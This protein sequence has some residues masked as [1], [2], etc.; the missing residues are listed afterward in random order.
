MIKVVGLR[1]GE[2]L[3]EELLNDTSKTIPT[4]HNK[5]MIAQEIQEEYETLHADIEELIKIANRF[6]NESIVAKMKEIV[7]E[8]KSMNSTYEVLDTH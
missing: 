4:Y 3:Y 6:E 1:P 5:I 2:K 8:F 7:P